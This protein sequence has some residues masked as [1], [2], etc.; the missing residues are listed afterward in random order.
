M[1]KPGKEIAV[2]FEETSEFAMMI[3]LIRQDYPFI[4]E[5]KMDD[6]ISA[7][8]EKL[9]YPRARNKFIVCLKQELGIE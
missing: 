4:T 2:S 8:M 5:E 1:R 6:A 7:C 9:N 3:E